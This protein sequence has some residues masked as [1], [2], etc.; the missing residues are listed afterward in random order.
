MSG[1]GQSAEWSAPGWTGERFS[2]G[3]YLRGGEY[4]Y[5]GYNESATFTV[6][7]QPPLQPPPP[8]LMTGQRIDR[9][10]CQM[11]GE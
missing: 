3:T 10:G 11:A 6:A 2:L 7:V 9:I 1:T 4:P 5:G 8:P